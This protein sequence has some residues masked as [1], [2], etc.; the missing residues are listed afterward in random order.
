MS[1]LFSSLY[2]SA[3]LAI[4]LVMLQFGNLAADSLWK[5]DVFAHSM[6][7]DKKARRVG[8]LL[9]ILIQENNG[10]TRQNNTTTSK[11]AAVD[12]SIASFLYGPPPAVC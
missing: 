10:A 4:L 1:R 11:Q 5:D 7:A 9:T 2:N 12:A 8:D 6:F 3:T